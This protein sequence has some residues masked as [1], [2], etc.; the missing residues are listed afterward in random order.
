VWACLSTI[1]DI[2]MRAVS[3]HLLKLG[4]GAP[5]LLRSSA[6]ARVAFHLQHAASG[7]C[8]CCGTVV[9]MVAPC[10]PPPAGTLATCQQAALSASAQLLSLMRTS[11]QVGQPS[12]L[13]I[14]PL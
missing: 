8:K 14:S 11:Q 13:L 1:T 12:F 2:R 6:A 5:Q 7:W 10:S 9:A 3:A 4:G